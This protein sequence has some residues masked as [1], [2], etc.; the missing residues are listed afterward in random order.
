MQCL[1][2]EPTNVKLWHKVVVALAILTIVALL[3]MA[4][5]T[6]IIFGRGAR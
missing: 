5:G 3:S 1:L 6:H 4:L 2:L